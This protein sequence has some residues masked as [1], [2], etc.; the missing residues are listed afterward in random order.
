MATDQ[1]INNKTLTGYYMGI[2][3]FG[4]LLIKADY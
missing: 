2:H 1:N 4:A 3:I